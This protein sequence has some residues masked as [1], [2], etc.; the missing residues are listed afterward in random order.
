MKPEAVDAMLKNYREFVGRCAYLENSIAQS[1]RNIAFLRKVLCTEECISIGRPLT[2]MP[3]GGRTSD[4]TAN[5]ALRLSDGFKPDQIREEEAEIQKA[6]AELREKAP[7]VAFVYSWLHGLP[8]R[9]AWI[10]ETKCI[11][12]T[13]WGVA[14]T[15]YAQK[16]EKAVSKDTLKRLKTKAMEKIYSMAE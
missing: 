8:E 5:T 13:P 15:L 12:N 10:V 14:A 11:D 16:Y 9:E 4:P 6:E 3:S 2:G 1:R 7:T